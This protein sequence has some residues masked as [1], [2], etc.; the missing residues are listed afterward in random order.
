MKLCDQLRLWIKLT[1]E[2]SGFVFLY[3]YLKNI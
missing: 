3:R 1:G 2:L